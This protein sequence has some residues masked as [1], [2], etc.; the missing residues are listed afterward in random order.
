MPRASPGYLSIVPGRTR[1]LLIV[2]LAETGG[3]QTYV[4]H[5]ARGMARAF[6]VTVA[7]HG[8]GP[9]REAVDAAG[10]RY[11]PLRH[12]QRRVNPWRDLLGLLEL[13]RV[14]RR[15]RPQIVH[16]N[17]SKA[18]VLGC[19]AA[20]AARVPVRIFT[21]H[22]WGSSW[23]PGRVYLWGDRLIRRTA[24]RVVCVAESELERGVEARTCTRG[25][26]LVIRNGV[27]VGSFRTASH[28]NPSPTLVWVGRLQEPKDPLT[29]VRALAALDGLG[30]RTLLVGEGGERGL[31]AGEL[32]AAGL[33]DR[34]ELLGERRDVKELL[35]R[36]DVFVLA[37]KSEALPV[38]ILEAMSAGLPVVAS[39]VGGV[40]ELVVDGKTGL[41]VAPG[42]AE[43]LA[44]ALARL[45]AD[46]ALRRRMGA[47]G[48]ARAEA[49]FD[50]QSFHEA[51]LDLYAR[52]L[53]AQ[54]FSVAA[55]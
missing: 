11:V 46:P 1:L 33:A 30:F 45:V 13:Y 2:T 51:H 54:G 42:D 4:A 40:A 6:D 49:L 28:D 31:V 27:D 3:A 29:L 10:A 12:V 7:A 21:V 50:L 20:F 22:G 18:G 24:T 17:S 52:E 48:R 15:V 35:A 14:C 25:Q 36:S 32:R 39:A 5:L 53:A 38:S 47:A 41:L 55:P 43:A 26:A 44:E 9:L 19:L 16:A 23:H 37:S 34:V 8:P